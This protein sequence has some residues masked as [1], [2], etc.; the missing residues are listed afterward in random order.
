MIS[1]QRG[2][3]AGT[4]RGATDREPT[5]TEQNMHALPAPRKAAIGALR[6]A[7][8]LLESESAPPAPSGTAVRYYTRRTAPIEARAWDRMVLSGEVPVYRPG[9]ELLVIC[10]DLHAWIEAHPVE[11]GKPE[12][13][14]NT[15]AIDFAS[16]KRTALRARGAK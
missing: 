16:F 13:S 1:E 11:R 15:T 12:P 14:D 4:F 3:P 9:R 5:R 8:E 10:N 2:L 6:A 7:L